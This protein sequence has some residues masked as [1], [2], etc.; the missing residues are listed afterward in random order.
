MHLIGLTGTHGAGKGTVTEILARMYGF[1]VYSVSEFLANEAL[2]RG[3][4][5][6]RAARRDIAN[7]LR[8][9]SPTALMEAVYATVPEGVER[10]V[11]EPQYTV[12]EVRCIQGKGG[13]VFALDA[14]L[15]ARYAR[16][17]GRGSAKDAVSFEEFSRSQE[18]EMRSKDADRQNLMAAM[19]AANLCLK[20][21]G[22]REELERTICAALEAYGLRRP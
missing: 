4:Q 11:I 18:L 20:N 9:S 13:I 21:D 2:R 6:D 5:P 7:E 8:H 22:T 19:S 17:R 3:M 14:S 15:E 10:V 12:E 1:A 16:I